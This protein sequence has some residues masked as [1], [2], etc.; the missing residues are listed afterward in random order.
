MRPEGGWL[1][2]GCGGAIFI[3]A[4]GGGGTDRLRAARSVGRCEAMRWEEKS[5]EEITTRNRG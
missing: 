4:D 2:S 5:R 1:R 3:R